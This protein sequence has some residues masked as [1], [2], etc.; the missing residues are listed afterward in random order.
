MTDASENTDLRQLS[1][2]EL[3]SRM[4]EQV[5]TLV[6]DELRLAQAEL[7]QKGKRAG[8]GAGLAGGAGVLALF[9]VGALVTAAIAA[10]AMVLPLWAAALV[11]G[12]AV[13]LLAGLL[14]LTGIGQVKRA[15][16][17]VPEAAIASTKRD[18]DVVKESVKR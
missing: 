14:A 10:L 8:T 9:G 18:I 15:T 12:G 6:R 7:K 11:V 5:S 4:S 16:P 13:L 1:V 2:G 17:V 3:V